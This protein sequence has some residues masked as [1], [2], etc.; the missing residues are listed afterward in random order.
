MWLQV[1]N[2]RS[3]S[4]YSAKIKIAVTQ[5]DNI[6]ISYLSL[7]TTDAVII[8]SDLP[9]KQ[10]VTESINNKFAFQPKTNRTRERLPYVYCILYILLIFPSRKIHTSKRFNEMMLKAGCLNLSHTDTHTHTDTP[11]GMMS[12]ST[13]TK[14]NDELDSGC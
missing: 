8:S 1:T 12:D 2:S 7:D 13:E 4:S 9:T 3:Q 10:K 5:D 6:Y 14:L 11:D